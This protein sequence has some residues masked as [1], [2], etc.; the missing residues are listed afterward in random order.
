MGPRA[1]RPK[2]PKSRKDMMVG[3]RKDFV[4]TWTN[5]RR[6]DNSDQKKFGAR[7]HIIRLDTFRTDDQTHERR[8]EREDVNRRQQCFKT[9]MRFSISCG[10]E[11]GELS[12]S[13]LV[14][15][16][17]IQAEALWSA[18]KGTAVFPVELSTDV[19]KDY[20]SGE[21]GEK[22]VTDLFKASSRLFIETLLKAHELSRD[23][24]NS[25]TGLSVRTSVKA[26]A[27]LATW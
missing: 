14:L 17:N 16:P 12:L 22:P 21:R 9:W 7:M 10:L 2:N 4:E 5:Q 25:P 26:C 19:W 6:W 15:V 24:R 18:L 27:S 11:H 3:N 23:L 20:V 1:D 8:S 13:S